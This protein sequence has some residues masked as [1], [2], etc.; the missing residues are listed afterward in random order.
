[1]NIHDYNKIILVGSSGSGKSWLAKRIAELTGYPLTHLDNEFW[2]L[3][4]VETPK[5]EWSARL[6]ELISGEQ[7]IIDGNYKSTMD[8]R[9][10]AADLV[11]F[12]DISRFVC[13][14]SF[15]KRAGKKRSDLPQYL[16]EPSGF[17]KEH[18]QSYK[19][20][21]EYPKTKRK[22]VIDLHEKYP[23]TPFLQIQSRRK[24]QRLL[25]S[26]GG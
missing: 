13:L 17:S 1:M 11:I 12:L 18:F 7:W 2:K 5:P 20:I 10:A 6:Q 22:T 26:W 4:W 8:V 19:W 25:R 14:W 3:E 16:D 9:Y 24:V 23:D 21:W 15:F